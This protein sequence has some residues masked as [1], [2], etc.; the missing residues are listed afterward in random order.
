MVDGRQMATKSGEV[1]EAGV[2]IVE[3]LA[4]PDSKFLKF[5]LTGISNPP[6]LNKPPCFAPIW[7]PKATEK[8]VFF[9]NFRKQII[10]RK[11]GDFALLINP[12]C[13]APSEIRGVFY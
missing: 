7:P 10:H 4:R 12:P 1:G 2:Y 8:V 6:T 3:L 13:F 5:G 9:C 11:S